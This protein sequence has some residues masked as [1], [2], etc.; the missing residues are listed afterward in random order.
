MIEI[1]ARSKVRRF[2]HLQH[3][4]R[5]SADRASEERVKKKL[6]LL[7]PRTALPLHGQKPAQ[8][9]HICLAGICEHV[10]T[11]NRHLTSSTQT[12][13]LVARLA[14][15]IRAGQGHW[16]AE[17]WRFGTLTSSSC[18]TQQWL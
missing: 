9:K 11:G 13:R 15:Q 4:A 5:V 14:G 3:R 16:C 12:S 17:L 18:S 6:N 8:A 1:P 2:R 10:G 7:L